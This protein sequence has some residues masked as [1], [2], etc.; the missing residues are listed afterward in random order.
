M[1]VDVLTVSSKGQ[2]VL[3]AS[4]RR[5]L[6]ITSGTKL[7]AYATGD[8]IMLKMIDIPTERDFK[9]MLDE[10]QQWARNVGLTEDEVNNVI[11]SVRKNKRV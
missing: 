3:P 10:A 1:S 2:V 5:K 8:V 9:S 4:M 11:K 6:S 7:A